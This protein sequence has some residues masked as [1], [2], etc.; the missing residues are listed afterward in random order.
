MKRFQ[1]TAPT[2]PDSVQGRVPQPGRG[3]A[4]FT[5]LELTVT[6]AIIAIIASIATP[7][8]HSALQTAR[9]EKARAEIRVIS[10][11]IDT[12]RRENHDV[13]P[14]TLA[15]VGYGDHRDPW[16]QPYLYLNFQTGTGSAMELGLQYGLIDPEALPPPA[17]TAERVGLIRTVLNL[18]DLA[19]ADRVEV[20]TARDEIK[21]R[22][23]PVARKD[24][25]LFPLNS[26]YDLF[27]LGINGI[28][29]VALGHPESMDDVI[30]A[31]D[32]GYFGL[33]SQY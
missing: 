29:K 9:I 30:R 21:D 28:T 13:L 6:I 19:P 15:D 7:M 32:G 14:P 3:E 18:L 25:F 17:P 20:E 31:N 1:S 10:S 16:G 33:A 24:Q 4:G 11:K 12:Y 2:S 26:D 27:S 22:V 23:E 8:Y 5:L